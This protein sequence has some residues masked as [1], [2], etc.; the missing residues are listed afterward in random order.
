MNTKTMSVREVIA[1]FGLA[2][3]LGAAPV[4]GQTTFEWFGTGDGVSF[5]DASNWL[6][7]GVPG[8]LDEAKFD[9]GMSDSI[10]FALNHTNA[11]C[12]VENHTLVFNL[13]GRSYTAAELIVG[14]RMTDVGSL[15]VN[16][17]NITTTSGFAQI[18]R[19]SPAH[20]SLVLTNGATMTN[21]G[22]L[23]VGDEGVGYF[24]IDPGCST[25]SHV[26]FLGNNAGA[27]GEAL[28]QGT[29]M[30]QTGLIVG[31]GGTGVITVN[32]SG[33]MNVATTI[34]LADEPFSSGTL[35]I[36]GPSAGVSAQS[37][38]SVG[39]FGHG[40]LN[41]TNGAS[42]TVGQLSVGD[43]PGAVGE[44]LLDGNGSTID[45][46]TGA[47]TVGNF[48]QGTLTVS[49]GA[50][51]TTAQFKIA[52]DFPSNVVVDAGT[53]IDSVG[54]NVGNRA[55]GT[56]TLAN[57]ASLQS[58]LVTVTSLGTLS[59]SGTISGP[60]LNDGQVK[61]DSLT[62]TGSYTQG[63]L[64]VLNIDIGGPNAGTEYGQLNVSGTSTLAGT[65]NVSLV[66]GF[67]PSSGE[68]VILQG[69]TITGNFAVENIP[70]G[71]TLTYEPN[72]VVLSIGGSCAADFNGDGQLS[73]FDVLTFLGAFDAGDPQADMNSDGS[74]DFF[75]VLTFLGL[76][77]AGC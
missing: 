15:T 41:V 22:D 55:A 28:V 61:P 65:L 38:V 62:I 56:L 25:T 72:R 33:S 17:G 47:T 59:G 7:A 48:G 31:N 67:N 43:E 39:N 77:S 34:K 32:G 18:G 35:N 76:F 73:F 37:T 30:L 63:L 24:Q 27:S 44:V 60:V 68:F 52:D 13:A 21:Q 23:R 75:D 66:N 9:S 74:F 3:G 16:G 40:V 29:W 8:S 19:L 58:P 10:N 46:L 64:G 6:P 71:S 53:I 50:Q 11:T 4:A 5:E 26:A 2:A 70:A 42:L 14:D 49:N 54:T 69:G 1:V 45:S 12:S 20:G 51:L 36:D 57:G